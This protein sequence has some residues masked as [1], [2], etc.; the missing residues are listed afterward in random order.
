EADGRVITAAAQGTRGVRGWLSR[1]IEMAELQQRV[2]ALEKQ[3]DAE[4]AR[5]DALVTDSKRARE[6]REETERRLQA[7]R[8]AQVE[9]QYQLQRLANEKRRLER[10]QASVQTE[11]AE[12]AER[13]AALARERNEVKGDLGELETRMVGNAE[14]AEQAAARQQQ[15]QAEVEDAGDRLTEARVQVGQHNEKLEAARRE[16]R[17]LE[18]ALEESQRQHDVAL[19]QLH[20]RLSQIEHYEATIADAETEM[21]LA[22]EQA[23]ELAGRASTLETQVQTAGEQLEVAAQHLADARQE[24][25]QLERELHATEINRREAEVKR[26]A[27][28]ERTIAELELDLGHA[29]VPYRARREDEGFEPLDRSTAQPEI[30]ELRDQIKRLGPV[31]LEAIDEESV[32]E[33]R[34]VD[35]I[36]QVE[37][38]DRAHRALQELITDLDKKSRERFMETFEAIRNHFAGSDGMFR[39]LFGGGSADIMLLPDDEGNVDWLSSGIE[40]RAKPPGKEPR[41]ISQL[42]GGE[43]AMTA[44]ALL[45]AIFKSKPSPFCILDEVDAALD[46]ANVE[47]FSAIVHQFLDRSHFI[48]I[49]H[50]KR[51]MAGCDRLYGVTM[52]ERGVS[53]RVSVRVEH[54]GEDGAIDHAAATDQEPVATISTVPSAVPT[55]GTGDPVNGKTGADREDES[56]AEPPLIET[57]PVSAAR[58]QLESAWE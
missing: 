9:A 26:E 25:S 31:N 29:Y 35:L 3:I 58:R 7:A 51:T 18:L 23:V 40:I 32:L 17:R 54:V 10:E 28:E 24:A 46:D 8:H 52:Q 33:E 56:R 27:L 16:R 57:K 39:R 48:I 37:D 36:S 4:S 55:N 15:L 21:R 43:K 50:N 30:E 1:R 12:L 38:I 5:L 49:T 2:T 42:S 45:M 53:R 20:R 6:R 13:Q 34:N 11:R 47:R 19:G 41:V 44:V 22:D 14:A